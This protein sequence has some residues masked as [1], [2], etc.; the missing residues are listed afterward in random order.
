MNEEIDLFESILAQGKDPIPLYPTYPADPPVLP[1]PGSLNVN[2]KIRRI[3]EPD[4]NLFTRVASIDLSDRKGSLLLVSDYFDFGQFQPHQMAMNDLKITV[5]ARESAQ[6]WLIS[7]GGLELLGREK[8]PG[9][10]RFNVPD[11]GPTAMVLVTTDLTLPDRIQAEV[12]R[13]RPLA[14]QLAIEQARIQLKWV[15]EINGRLVADGHRLYDPTD[16]KAYKL[17]PGIAGAER[18]GGAPGQVRRADQ[19]GRG[20][21]GARRLCRWPGPRP[22]APPGR[23]GS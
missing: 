13:V 6:A 2:Q 22:A 20:R 9:G 23:S 12:E 19:V 17:P 21:A 14:V 11:Y 10:V 1:P 8:V 5:P 3:K 4:P 16:P 7:P 15:A 18:R